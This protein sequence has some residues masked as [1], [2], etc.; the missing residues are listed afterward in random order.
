[1]KLKKNEH[2]HVKVDPRIKADYKEA[3]KYFNRSMAFD[4]Y[5]HMYK[6]VKAYRFMEGEK[7][8]RVQGKRKT[9]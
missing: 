6:V 7:L 3:C 1:M 8:E 4:I 2:L 5:E 9:A